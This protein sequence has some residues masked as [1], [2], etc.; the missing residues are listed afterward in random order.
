MLN[1]IN[2]WLFNREVEALISTYGLKEDVFVVNKYGVKYIDLANPN[3]NLKNIELLRL[4]IPLE[5]LSG[6]CSLHGF[7]FIDSDIIRN[8]FINYHKQSEKTE[9]E[10]LN[11]FDDYL[12]FVIM[13]EAGHNYNKDYL[14]VSPIKRYIMYFLGYVFKRYRNMP[15]T[16]FLKSEEASNLEANAD[17]YAVAKAKVSLDKYRDYMRVLMSG[18]SGKEEIELAIKRIDKVCKTFC[19]NAI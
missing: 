6:A 12:N 8:N 10:I 9:D 18:I 13:H 1:F 15:A 7:I 19:V 17:L 16:D 5:N 4:M 11:V 2:N 14:R 3:E